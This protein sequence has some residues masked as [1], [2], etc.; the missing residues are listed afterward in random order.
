MNRHFIL[1]CDN[2]QVAAFQ[3]WNLGP[4]AVPVRFLGLGT[5][6]IVENP[7]TPLF[8]QVWALAQDLF[9]EILGEAVLGHRG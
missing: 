5:E 7:D 3:L 4:E 9:L 6:W 2:P 8:L 1:K